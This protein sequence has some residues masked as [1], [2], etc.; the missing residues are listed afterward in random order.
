[1]RDDIKGNRGFNRKNNARPGKSNESYS[2]RTGGTGK[3]YDRRLIEMIEQPDQEFIENR[4]EGKNPVLEALKSGRT[5]EKLL[6]AR[7]NTEGSIRE[8][9][10]RAKENKIVIQEVDR[11]RLDEISQSGAHQGVVAYVTPYSYVEVEDILARAREKGEEPFLIIL[12]EITDPHN[13]GA[14]IR[15]AECCGAHG[16]IIPKRRS[17]GLTPA[18]IKASAGAVEYLPVAKVTNLANLLDKLK[19]HGIWVAGA[20]LDG[21]DYTKQN[22]KGPIAVVIGSEGRGMGRLI[23]EKCDFIVKIPLKGSIE[24]LNASVAAGILMYEVVRQRG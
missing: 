12:D 3:R 6:I 15:S 20:D 18:A 8:I 17:V 19:E 21:Q 14:I 7:G 16:V 11:K 22:L 2:S 5:V 4:I 24:S 23:K 13:L 10:S 9:I 1:M